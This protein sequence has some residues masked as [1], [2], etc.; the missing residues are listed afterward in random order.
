MVSSVA[1]RPLGFELASKLG[2]YL[3]EPVPAEFQEAPAQD[4]QHP[5][6]AEDQRGEGERAE[7]VDRLK[8]CPYCSRSVKLRENGGL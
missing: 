6:G 2:P 8:H 7:D 5:V 3:S 4:H 1:I